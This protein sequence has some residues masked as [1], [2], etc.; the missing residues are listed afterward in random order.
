MTTEGVALSQLYKKT[1]VSLALDEKKKTM[2]VSGM[3]RASPEH[4]PNRFMC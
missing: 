2:R 4:G 3:A 1:T